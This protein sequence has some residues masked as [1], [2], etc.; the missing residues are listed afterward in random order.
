M[1]NVTEV[2]NLT[3]HRKEVWIWI[4]VIRLYKIERM[5][6]F[7]N[8]I[9]QYNVLNTSSVCIPSFASVRQGSSFSNSTRLLFIFLFVKLNLNNT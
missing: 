5:R 6:K 9:P 7:H 2:Y 3:F 4:R 8:N 1:W